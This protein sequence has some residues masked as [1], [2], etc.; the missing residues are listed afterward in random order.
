MY[1]QFSVSP[2][3]L[4]TAVSGQPSLCAFQK[5]FSVSPVCLPTT[6]SGQPIV[7][8]YLCIYFPPRILSHPSVPTHQLSGQPRCLSLQQLSVSPVCLPINSDQTIVLP[9]LRIFPQLFSVSPGCAM[10]IPTLLYLCITL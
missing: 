9:S 2:V 6:F 4:P 7:W 10:C 3:C 5:Q 1:E 8:P